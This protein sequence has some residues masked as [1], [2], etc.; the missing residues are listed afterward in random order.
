M[1][2]AEKH[3]KTPNHPYIWRARYLVDAELQPLLPP[4]YTGRKALGKSTGIKVGGD[5]VEAQRRIDEFGNEVAWPAIEYAERKLNPEPKPVLLFRANRLEHPRS[6]RAR[7]PWAVEIEPSPDGAELPAPVMPATSMMP[8]TAEQAIRDWIKGQ[9]TKIPKPRAIINKTNR[10]ADM[11]DFVRGLRGVTEI[12]DL[13]TITRREGQAWKD[14]LDEINDPTGNVGRDHLGEVK[15]IFS[16]ADKQNRFIDLPDGNPF[17]KVLLPLLRDPKAK[18][19]G[20]TDSEAKMILL[21]ARDCGDERLHWLMLLEALTGGSHSEIADARLKHVFVEDGVHCLDIT[22][23]G[24]TYLDQDGRKYTPKLKTSDRPR[25]MP[26]HSAILD[27]GFLDRVERMRAQ[28]GLEASLFEDI[29]PDRYLRRNVEASDM[30]MP[31]LRNLGIENKVD[32]DGAVIGLRDTYSWRHWFESQL[33]AT[34]KLSGSTSEQR[35]YLSGH[36]GSGGKHDPHET[37]YPKH[38]PIVMKPIVWAIP[39]PIKALTLAA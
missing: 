36:R 35:R 20:Y 1:R 38:P 4:P 15:A 14:H 37:A 8:L 34:A 28:Y 29:E 6:S 18:R 3:R 39:N 31:F 23:E 17:K 2:H 12:V 26:L 11:I 24:R 13:T 19:L 21:A 5:H 7:S 16:H 27:A 9:G 22:P 10:L 33:Q 25:L 32:A 30:T